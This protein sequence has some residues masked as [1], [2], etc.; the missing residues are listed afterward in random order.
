MGKNNRRDFIKTTGL[1]GA[2]SLIPFGKNMA[3][4]EDEENGDCV[5]I[6]TET[7]GLFHWT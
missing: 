3:Q 4:P 7:A 6:P 1:I 5:L 2:V